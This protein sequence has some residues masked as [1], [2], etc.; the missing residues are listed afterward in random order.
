M[1]AF[2]EGLNVCALQRYTGAEAGDKIV[3]NFVA[4]TYSENCQ[5]KLKRYALC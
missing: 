1:S 5:I 4:G 2:S 3:T